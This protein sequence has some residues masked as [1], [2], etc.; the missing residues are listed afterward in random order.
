MGSSRSHRR[1]P[2][3]AAHV[4]RALRAELAKAKRMGEL[5]LG[6]AERAEAKLGFRL[7]AGKLRL[8]LSSPWADEGLAAVLTYGANKY[9]AHNY[10][11]GLSWSETLDSLKRHLAAFIKGEDIDPESGLPHIDHIACNAHFLSHFQKLGTGVDDRWKH[12]TTIYERYKRL[13]AE[14]HVTQKL[15]DS[16]AAKR[17]GGSDRLE[18]VGKKQRHRSRGLRPVGRDPARH[19]PLARR[20]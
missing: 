3:T 5:A 18:R 10:R 12:K 1:K 15:I 8:S 16:A 19:Q 2:A 11:K 20:S 9:V 17:R 13:V 6:S 14:L 7:N 4:V